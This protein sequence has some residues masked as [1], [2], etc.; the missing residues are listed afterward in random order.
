[1]SKWI[2]S[3]ESLPEKEKDVL[4]YIKGI[5]SIDRVTY[6]KDGNIWACTEK[7]WLSHW[8][9]LPESPKEDDE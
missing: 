6:P 8:R 1:M 2:K 7:K 4:I 5:I 9:S 3:S